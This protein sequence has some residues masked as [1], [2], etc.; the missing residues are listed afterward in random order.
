MQRQ[1][2]VPDCVGFYLFSIYPL[3]IEPISQAERD[4]H[5]G[6]IQWVVNQAIGYDLFEN[7]SVK[8]VERFM[9]RNKNMNIEQLL[10]T[11]KYSDF[12]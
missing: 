10:C 6:R 3:P 5:M 12:L 4:V 2:I 1:Y 11:S 9:S 7:M 8:K